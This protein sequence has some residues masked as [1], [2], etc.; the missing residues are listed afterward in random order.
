MLD[1]GR[2]ARA[3]AIARRALRTWDAEVRESYHCFE[4]FLIETGRGCGWHQFSGLSTP[5]MIFYAACHC[6][7]RLTTGFDAWVERV[8]FNK[9]NTRM[10]AF[11]KFRPCPASSR[12]SLLVCMKS[13]R[14]YHAEWNGGKVLSDE[15]VPGLL[16]ISLPSVE[17]EGM[18]MVDGG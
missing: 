4:H 8:A 18:L 13:G 2:P 9:K 14:G 3:L 15:L 11:I 7:G 12:R 1:L 5:V 10:N 17:R 6:P 16:A